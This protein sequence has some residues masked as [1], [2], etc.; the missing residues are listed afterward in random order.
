MSVR[1]ILVGKIPAREVNATEANARE[2]LLLVAGGRGNLG[3]GETCVAAK[4]HALDGCTREDDATEIG[5]IELCIGEVIVGEIATGE[6]DARENDAGEVFLLKASGG[7]NLGKSEPSYVGKNCS[8]DNGS[9]EVGVPVTVELS[10]CR[11]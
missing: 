10:K 9:R 11:G 6:I 3:E 1:Q 7:G 5:R 8:L 2:I 4:I